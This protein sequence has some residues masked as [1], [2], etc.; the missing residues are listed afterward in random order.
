M[1]QAIATG[2]IDLRGRRVASLRTDTWHVS[3]ALCHY[4]GCR[5]YGTPR[6]TGDASGVVDELRRHDIDTVL[7]WTAHDYA[8]SLPGYTRL[9]AIDGSLAG[10]AVRP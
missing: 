4:A 5:Y 8:L 10:L 6:Q 9:P 7:L 2:G 3:L 1:H